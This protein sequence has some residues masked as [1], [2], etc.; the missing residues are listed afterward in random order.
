MNLK[1]LPVA[2]ALCVV[3]GCSRHTKSEMGLIS[4][5]LH[6]IQTNQIAIC[7]RLDAMQVQMAGMPKMMSDSGFFYYTNTLDAMGIQEKNIE[8]AVNSETRRVGIVTYTN[9]ANFQVDAIDVLNQI[10]LS[11]SDDSENE[12]H[13]QMAANIGDIQSDLRK[14]KIRL[15]TY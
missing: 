8:L 5:Q 4:D 1:I 15:G 7:Q 2:I 14:I 9:L 3:A 10:K 11:E 12:F 13:L 6:Q